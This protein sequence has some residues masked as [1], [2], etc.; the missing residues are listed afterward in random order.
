MKIGMDITGNIAESGK[1][2]GFLENLGHFRSIQ[3]G[4]L[5][6]AGWARE[7]AGS[8]RGVAVGGPEAGGMLGMLSVMSVVIY[9]GPRGPQTDFRKI[10]E[11]EVQTTSLYLI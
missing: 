3:G 11:N 7:A 5:L 4:R 2:H 9:M 10:H 6:A 8:V 1:N